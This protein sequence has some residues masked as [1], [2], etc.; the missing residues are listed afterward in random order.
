MARPKKVVSLLDGVGSE[1]EVVLTDA[2]TETT[3]N[4]E[5]AEKVEEKEI[6][7]MGSPEWNDYVLGHLLSDEMME[8]SPTVDGLRRIAPLILGPILESKPISV[9]A[10]EFQTTVSYEIKFLWQLNDP[11]FGM[12]VSFG[13]VGDA[14]DVNADF[15]YNQYRGPMAETR[16]EGRA[17]KKALGLKRVLMADEINPQL[18]VDPKDKSNGNQIAVITNMCNRMSIDIPKF[19]TTFAEEVGEKN[20]TTIENTRSEFAAKCIQR[21]NCYQADEKNSIYLPIPDSIKEIV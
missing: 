9:L 1:D 16:A 21:L 3:D 4:T 14:T 8:G 20:V 11:R 15:P 17:L 18:K 6:P 2:I 13:G 7:L 12:V 5:S 19:L 10:N